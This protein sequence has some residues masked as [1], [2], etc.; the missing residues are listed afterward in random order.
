[1]IST[2]TYVAV[3]LAYAAAIP[4]LNH[5]PS[6]LEK[7]AAFQKPLYNVEIHDVIYLEPHGTVSLKSHHPYK[8]CS[9]VIP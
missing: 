4:Y 2:V 3:C 1:M 8:I 5:K 9:A 6:G 7:P